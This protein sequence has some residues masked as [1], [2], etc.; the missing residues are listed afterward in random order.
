MIQTCYTICNETPSVLISR[1]IVIDYQKEA[2]MHFCFIIEERYRNESMPMVIAD[3]LRQ[4][5]SLLVR[6]PPKEYP[7]VVKPTNGRSCRSAYR[8]DPPSNLAASE[9]VEERENFFL[10][11]G[12]VENTDINDFPSFGPVSWAKEGV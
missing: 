8:L 6:L 3:Q 5:H 4:S 12:Y 9:I 1:Q 11:Q 2:K 10:A 7:L